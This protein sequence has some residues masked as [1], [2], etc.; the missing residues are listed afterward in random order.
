MVLRATPPPKVKYLKRD[1]GLTFPTFNLPSPPAAYT[2]SRVK[3]LSGR[4]GEVGPGD[5]VVA[6]VVGAVDRVPRVVTVGPRQ[7][8]GEGRVEVEEGPGNDGVV[9]EGHI[10]PDDADGKTNS[11]DGP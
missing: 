1:T 8:A 2:H 5:I 9:V 7:S 6:K 4:P 10:Q 3:L 11:C